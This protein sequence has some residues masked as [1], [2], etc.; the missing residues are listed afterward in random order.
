MFKEGN[1]EAALRE[2]ETARRAERASS[3]TTAGFGYAYNTGLG[4]IALRQ[5]RTDGASLLR[6]EP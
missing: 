2:Y 6:R 5:G 3:C 1:D 4:R